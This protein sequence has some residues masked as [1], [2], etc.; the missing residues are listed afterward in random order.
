V[1]GGQLGI[2]EISLAGDDY[3]SLSDVA[4]LPQSLGTGEMVNFTVNYAPTS[5]GEHTATVSI[6]DDITREIHTV[7]LSGSGFD[8]TIYTLP[9]IETWDDTTAPSFP[10]GWSTI[11][12]STSTSAYLRTSNSS[13]YSEPNCV[14][15]ANS[16]DVAAELILISP[17]IDD[18][19]ELSNIRVR[20]MA[21]G[22][23]DYFL[24]VGTMSDPDDA[25]TFSL[26][27]ELTVINGWNEYAVN[28]HRHPSRP[29][30][31]LPY[32]LGG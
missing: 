29:A 31:Y 14:Q 30:K 25:T 20:I 1:G 27:Q 7:E 16:S 19:I 13:P 23:T 3:F 18:D 24:Q 8:A 28:L 21:K 32:T 26:A 11:L 17:P 22:G 9:Q 5:S 15:M 6:T 10:L 2:T 12:N 4:D